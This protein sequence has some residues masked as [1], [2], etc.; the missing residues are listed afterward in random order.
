MKPPYERD[1]IRY[2][3]TPLGNF[4]SVTTILRETDT[5]KEKDRLRKW[6]KKMD[7]VH[8]T[9][10]SEATRDEA[11]KRGTKIHKAIE[12][13]MKGELLNPPQSPYFANALPLLKYL[14]SEWRGSEVRV[15]HPSGY[16]GTLD[17]LSIYEDKAT[18]LDFTTSNRLK[19]KEWLKNKFLQC[20]A[21]AIAHDYL[22]DSNIQQ[23]AVVVLTPE[24]FQVFTDS[25][26]NHES[27]WCARLEQFYG[28]PIMANEQ[29]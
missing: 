5:K 10:T 23:T 18:I 12:L 1:G 16:A 13:F 20:T 22:H 14:K 7:K 8:G 19:I 17:L 3:E 6:Q 4:P 26:T 29:G 24:R 15:Y 21:Y 2:Y 27:E 9:G 11:G 28:L 25:V